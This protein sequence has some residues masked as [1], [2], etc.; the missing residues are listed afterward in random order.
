MLTYLN[1]VL[2]STVIRNNYQTGFYQWKTTCPKFWGSAVV[3]NLGERTVNFYLSFYILQPQFQ[4]PTLLMAVTEQAE[5][6][7]TIMMDSNYFN[8]SSRNASILYNQNKIL[9][10]LV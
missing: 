7:D 9:D 8:Y 5:I 1:E 4:L 6:L 2:H 10:S 3:H